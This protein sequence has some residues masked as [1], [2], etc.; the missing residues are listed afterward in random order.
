MPLL[1]LTL[2]QPKTRHLF[3][4]LWGHSCKVTH[5]GEGGRWCDRVLLVLGQLL[6][7]Q[8]CPQVY[9]QPFAPSVGRVRQRLRCQFRT[10]ALAQLW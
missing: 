1:S 2:L 5:L 4:V 6:P 7:Y 8:L 10:Q 3:D 9:S